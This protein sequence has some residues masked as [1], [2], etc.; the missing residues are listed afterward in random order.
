MSGDDIRIVWKL[1]KAL[2]GLLHRMHAA[3]REIGPANGS[4]KKHIAGNEQV[5]LFKIETT[6]SWRMPRRMKDLSNE[7][8]TA[9]RVAIVLARVE[10]GR[11]LCDRV[12]RHGIE[13]GKSKRHICRMQ[14]HGKIRIALEKGI[15]CGNM[16]EMSMGQDDDFRC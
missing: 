4:E 8:P 11:S 9:E 10:R 2:D 15:D 5:F 3:T 6:A 1:L 16:I 13:R 14:I 12:R 7:T